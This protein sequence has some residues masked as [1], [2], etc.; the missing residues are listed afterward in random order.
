MISVKQVLNFS[1]GLSNLLKSSMK[2]PV[3]ALSANS[4]FTRSSFLNRSLQTC[5]K[6]AP[7]LSQQINSSILIQERGYK[8][9]TRLRKRCKHCTFIWRNGRI[10][11]ECK[12]HPRHKQFHKTSLLPGFDHVG[13]GYDPKATQFY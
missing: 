1:L 2:Y 5:C 4:L 6:S 9:K 13:N 7:I 8:A 11:V 10:Y 12:E 3:Y